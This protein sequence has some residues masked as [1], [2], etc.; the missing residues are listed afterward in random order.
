MGRPKN[1]DPGHLPCPPTSPGTGGLG[2]G[3]HWLAKPS[4]CLSAHS[5]AF[6]LWRALGAEQRGSRLV[7]ATLLAW[8]Q[9]RPLPGGP[10]PSGPQPTDKTHRRLLA[11][12][13]PPP[14][15][16][17]PSPTATGLRRH[18]VAIQ[19]DLSG[20]WV[21]SACQAW[22]GAP[23]PALPSRPGEGVG[24]GSA[25]GPPYIPAHV[26]ALPCPCYRFSV[27]SWEHSGRMPPTPKHR[28]QQGSG[29]SQA[30]GKAPQGL[31]PMSRVGQRGRGCD[32]RSVGRPG[33]GYSERPLLPLQAT[34]TLHNLQL[35][36][37]FKAT[38]QE[39]Y[40]QLLLALLTQVHYVLELH[41]PW[42]LP[43]PGAREAATSSPLR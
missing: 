14:P 32:G 6:Q 10:S 36:Q 1:R 13:L 34:N 43:R 22:G 17:R 7:L 41:L 24:V 8:L 3:V 23:S 33:P 2:H 15:H 21:P 18:P 30:H 19:G 11:V 38:V 42:E 20:V 16:P 27:P 25:S 4:W 9:E 40:P 12:S 26:P 29:Q 28:R 37:E 31:G 5:H 39:A 35:A